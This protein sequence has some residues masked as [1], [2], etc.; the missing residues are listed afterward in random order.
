MGLR[1][2]PPSPRGPNLPRVGVKLCLVG[3]AA[4][5]KSCLATRYIFRRHERRYLRTYRARIFRKRLR[6]DF[7]DG[8]QG[9]RVDLELWD[10]PGHPTLFSVLHDVY[11]HRADGVLVA[12]DV[13]RPRTIQDVPFWIKAA[14]RA[15]AKADTRI[16]VN[17]AD[18]LRGRKVLQGMPRMARS[19]DAPW[20]VVSAASGQNV[21]G[22][23]TGLI[24]E[25]LLRRWPAAYRDT[26]WPEAPLDATGRALAPYPSAAGAP[27]IPR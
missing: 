7:G 3:D 15:I 19:F 10:A 20:A 16:L 27:L 1:F 2:V 4:V 11:F 13:T 17:K 23:F 9:M 24:G 5:G 14:R 22:A 12:C 21:D 18:R 8:G 6:A 25:I 26:P